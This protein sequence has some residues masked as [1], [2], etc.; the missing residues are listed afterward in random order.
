MKS[1]ITLLVFL[2]L[3]GGSYMVLK[4]TSLLKGILPNDADK[5]VEQHQDEEDKTDECI[6]RCKSRFKWI[7]F[8]KRHA[9]IKRCT[10]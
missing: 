2:I 5:L 1:I 4:R 7:K 8:H 10:P 3:L 6:G 9:C